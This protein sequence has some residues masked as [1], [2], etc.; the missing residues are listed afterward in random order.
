MGFSRNNIIEQTYLHYIISN[1][2]AL[3]FGG[4]G[5]WEEAGGVTQYVY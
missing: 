5:Q 2:S 4:S 3:S 1:V